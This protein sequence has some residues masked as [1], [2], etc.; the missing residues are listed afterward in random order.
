MTEVER[1]GADPALM[2]RI[3]AVNT[4]RVLHGGAPMTLTKIV[5][6]TGL[7][8]KTAEAAVERLVAEGL[9]VELPPDGM[10]R[11]VGRPARSFRFRAEAGYVLGVD[12]GVHR[13]TALLADLRGQVVAR[14]VAGVSRTT[15]RAARI[16]ATRA[17]VEQ[18]LAAADVGPEAVW[19]TTAGTPGL[20]ADGGYVSLCHV[21]PQWSEFPLADELARQLP[22]RVAAENDT[23]LSA[24]A[25]R[26]QGA[27][28]DVD[29]MVWVLTGRR[30]SAAILIG[31]ELYRGA[32][33]AA[34]EIGWVPE[35][36]WST[37]SQQ[38]L[39]FS[40]AEHTRAGEAAASTISR[41]AAGDADARR[42]L[43]QFAATLAPGLTALTL[44]LN[45]RCLVIGGGVA[46]A[47]DLL[48]DAVAAHMRPHC[49]RMPDLRASTLGPDSVALGAV[50]HSLDRVEQV[51]F[52]TGARP[53]EPLVTRPRHT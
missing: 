43:E 31:G 6:A 49:L 27:A 37:L 4:L 44:V 51:L 42:E 50:R 21:L 47:G 29:S 12:I 9:A 14:A 15:G 11:A 13:V 39:S 1:R 5:E 35:L 53:P 28:R 40:G 46:A 8:R 38:R 41:A 45:P 10:E 33:G 17:V 22:G 3:N 48:L 20:V 19:A 36:G 34:G 25:E 18:C 24:V 30:I 52:A 2:R 7:A 16:A 32:D 26:W 23:N